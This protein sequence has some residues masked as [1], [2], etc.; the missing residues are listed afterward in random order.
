MS[1]ELVDLLE[2]LLVNQ[3]FDALPS[4][5]LALLMLAR[6]RALASGVE[7]LVS[8]FS[9]FLNA[10]FSAQDSSVTSHFRLAGERDGYTLFA[11]PCR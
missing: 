8:K 2:R 1:D 5:E 3:R 4:G 9:Q 6:D 10:R 7:G 11:D